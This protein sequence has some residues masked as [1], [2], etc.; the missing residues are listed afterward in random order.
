MQTLRIKAVEAVD[1][2]Q[3]PVKLTGL[4]IA[5]QPWH[6]HGRE[7]AHRYGTAKQGIEKS[8][9]GYI[10][11]AMKADMK[12]AFYADTATEAQRLLQVHLKKNTLE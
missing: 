10:A 8:G 5:D 7:P 12:Y 4:G 2:P 3:A 1:K 9:G 11:W 6:R